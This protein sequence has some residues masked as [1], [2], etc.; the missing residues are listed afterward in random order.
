MNMIEDPRRYTAPPEPQAAGRD[1]MDVSHELA[2]Q[3]LCDADEQA[4]A[5]YVSTIPKIQLP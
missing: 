4:A 3:E 5:E 2:E 1:E